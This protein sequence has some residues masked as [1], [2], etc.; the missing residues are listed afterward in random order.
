M[1]TAAAS[2]PD[3]DDAMFL[4]RI[5]ARV[6]Q[7][8]A[9]RGMARRVLAD[10]SGVSERY[11]AQL[12]TGKGNASV[13]VLRAVAGAM[14]V[15]VD[16]LIDPRP[17]QSSLYQQVRARLRHAG[18]AQLERCLAALGS[19]EVATPDER[20]IALI[21]LR[22]AGKS[23]LGRALAERAGLPFIELVQHIEQHA[24]MPLAE[25]FSLGGQATYRRLER[26]ALRSVL[27]SGERAV[28]AVG[29]S[30][31]SEPEAFADLLAGA[32]TVWVQAAP[33]VHMERVLAQGDSR[34]MADNPDAMTDLK[35]IL[36][37]RAA[38]YARADESLDTSG[39]TPE[40][41]LNALLALPAIT[42]YLA[43]IESA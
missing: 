1:M 41:S 17:D 22:G 28:M 16:D 38:L 6:R 24:G 21:G 10:A 8:R 35:R 15:S 39:A 11:L 20:C 27:A 25:I 36:G 5:G 33:H 7:L 14:D 19:D 34:P 43:H 23:T 29:G 18:E 26:E 2:A 12:E 13:L 40:Q 9:L 30:L 32:V 4:A 3:R 31:V 37:E 42:D